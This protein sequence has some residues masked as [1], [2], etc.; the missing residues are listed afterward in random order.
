[1]SFDSYMN[2]RSNLMSKITENLEDNK[3]KSFVDDRFWKPTRGQDGSGYAVVR[4]LPGTDTEKTPWVKLYSHAFKGGMTGK[5]YI[6]NSRTTLGESDPV[7]DFNTK[8]WNSGIESN[9]DQARQQ[10]RRTSYI[11]NV[12]VLKDPENPSN[13]GKVFMY[14]FGMKIFEKIMNAMQPEFADEDP[15]NP[16]DLMEGANFKIKIRTVSGY[17]NYD[18]SDWDRPGAITQ[19][20]DKLRSVFDAQY[21]VHAE[22][23]P[24]KFKSFDELKTKLDD[25]LGN[26]EVAVDTKP[27]PVRAPTAETTET[28]ADFASVFKEESAPVEK[29]D[30]V[31]I[32]DYF[33]NLTAD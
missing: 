13:E 16:F 1:M 3:K 8:L 33:K 23:A 2:N 27:E 7:S 18:S 4:F 31:G 32:E 9:K 17:P 25:V 26:T 21:D 28:E 20:M 11:T 22:V 24:D 30:D 15:I 5:W 12:L 10:K 6:E 19:D 29:T 14:K